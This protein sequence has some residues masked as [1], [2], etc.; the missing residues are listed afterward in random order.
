MQ[1][2]PSL[3]AGHWAGMVTMRRRRTATRATALAVPA[4]TPAARTKFCAMAGQSTQA[5]MARTGLTEC[6]PGASSKPR[7]AYICART[8]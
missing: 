2:V 3:W 4:S 8:S 7:L 6:G 1:D 5:A